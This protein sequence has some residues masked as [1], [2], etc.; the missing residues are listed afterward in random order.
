MIVKLPVTN[1]GPNERAGFK[2]APVIETPN[3]T[4]RPN[5]K[6]IATPAGGA[7][8]YFFEAVVPYILT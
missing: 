7:I 6:P 8:L 4:L 1:V 3:I 2:E 5:V